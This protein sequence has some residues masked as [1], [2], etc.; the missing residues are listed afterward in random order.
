MS[1]RNGMDAKMTWQR[2]DDYLGKSFSDDLWSDHAF[3]QAI[4]LMQK[5]T[6]AE[7]ASVRSTWPNRSSDW[8][9]RCADTLPWASAPC[10]E[11]ATVLLEMV[12]S[13]NDDLT[14]SAADTLR[15]FDP[16]MIAA[17]M[18][19]D[20]EERLHDVARRPGLS[21]NAIQRLLD[22]LQEERRP[23]P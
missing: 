22:G 11:I 12:Q 4:G 18:A 23:E 6:P 10:Q 1:C 14:I 7:F 5:L 16:G 8:Q 19:P 2:L 20:I 13:P 15:E 9:T 17:M 3:E 21:A